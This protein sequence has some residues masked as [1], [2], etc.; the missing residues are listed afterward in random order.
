MMIEVAGAQLDIDS[1][2][3]AANLERIAA[4]CQD[5]ST[6]DLIVFPEL[7]NIGQVGERNREFG[8][9]YAAAA[10]HI[11]GPFT[12][13]V[14]K[15]D[16][17]NGSHV[18]IGMAER[19]PRIRGTT[20]DSAVVIDP[21]GDVVGVQRKLHL[22]GE[23]HHYFAVGDEIVVVPTEL[24]LIS[25][26][27]C[28]D[29]YFPEVARTAALRGSESLCGIFNVT[30]RPDWPQRLTHLAAVRAYEN[31]QHTVFVNRVGENHGRQF[32]GGSVIARPPGVISAIAQE[33]CETVFAAT[34]DTDLVAAERSFRP[35][36]A[37]RRPDIYDLS[38]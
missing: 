10:E 3:T 30:H 21:G 28:Y 27:I 17:I 11:P 35:V 33:S 31:M 22:A 12:D 1:L 23:E 16:R 36:F 4:A 7:S 24:G 2:D 18:I 34:I 9:R 29:A 5:A 25:V 19:H 13:A 20:Y 14:S 6:A 32:G 38:S 15:L 37:D 8:Q 26:V